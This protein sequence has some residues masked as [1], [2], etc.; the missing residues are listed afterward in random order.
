MDL[1]FVR[2]KRMRANE[3]LAGGIAR[4]GISRMRCDLH[5]ETRGL[6]I[7][8]TFFRDVRIW[9]SQLDAVVTLCKNY[10]CPSIQEFQ[11]RI[12]SSAPISAAKRDNS[13]HGN[14]TEKFYSLEEYSGR[15]GW[16]YF[17]YRCVDRAHKAN[18]KND[19]FN[20]DCRARTRYSIAFFQTLLFFLLFPHNERF[21]LIARY[22]FLQEKSFSNEKAW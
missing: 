8:F 20:R 7:G 17:F 3:K 11:C 9:V 18:W 16:T 13:I 15:A 2:V 4:R 6:Q 10:P 5:G 19:K 1:T 22:L 14:I 12:R 21:L